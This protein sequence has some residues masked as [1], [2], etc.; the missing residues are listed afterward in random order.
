MPRTEPMNKLNF[1]LNYHVPQFLP[2]YHYT[3]THTHAHTHNYC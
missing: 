1:L 2:M 3:H